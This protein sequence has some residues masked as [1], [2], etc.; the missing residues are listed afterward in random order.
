[1]SISPWSHIK[2]VFSNLQRRAAEGVVQLIESKTTELSVDMK[3]TPPLRTLD[4]RPLV[5]YL[6]FLP[7]SSY[8]DESECCELVVEEEECSCLSKFRTRIVCFEPSLPNHLLCLILNLIRLGD[9]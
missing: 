3:L 5:Q 8:I 7:A 2:L 4:L 9:C 6:E 1:M